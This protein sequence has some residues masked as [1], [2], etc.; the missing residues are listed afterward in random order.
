LTYTGN[1]T[2]ASSETLGA[3]T[4]NSGGSVLNLTNGGAAVQTL[5]FASLATGNSGALNVVSTGLGTTSK[6]IFTT[7][8]GI[9]NGVVT[10]GNTGARIVVNG[11]DFAAY[12][13]TPG[14]TAFSAYNTS[15][16]LDAAATTETM[17]MT[18]SATL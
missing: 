1:G 11:T 13:A 3:L 4:L 5:T 2:A 7:A 18:S 14:L 9:S 17:K 12:S 8:P 16:N 6:M 10:G 15:N